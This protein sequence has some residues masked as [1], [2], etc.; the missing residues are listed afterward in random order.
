MIGKTLR[1]ARQAK[2]YTLKEVAD[3]IISFGQ[4]SKIE[5]DGKGETTS[6]KHFFEILERLNL[7]IAEFSKLTEAEVFKLRSEYSDKIQETLRSNRY[8]KVDELIEELRKHFIK[9]QNNYFKH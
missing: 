4:L 1:N 3:G 6:V 9:T 2:G 7:T 8:D 5:N